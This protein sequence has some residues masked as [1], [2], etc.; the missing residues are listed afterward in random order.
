MAKYYSNQSQK[1]DKWNIGRSSN[2]KGSIL[3]SR[4]NRKS[5]RTAGDIDQKKK[6]GKK[7]ENVLIK[8]GSSR[9]DQRDT[10]YFDQKQLY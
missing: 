8:L 6:K 7:K 4:T 1:L 5:L 9:N 10:F 2:R 3:E